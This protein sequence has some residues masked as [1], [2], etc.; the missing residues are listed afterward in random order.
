MH[1]TLVTKTRGGDCQA[2]REIRATVHLA[3]SRVVYLFSDLAV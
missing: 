2:S 3:L 1:A